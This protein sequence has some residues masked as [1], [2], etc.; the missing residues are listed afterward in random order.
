LASVAKIN[1]IEFEDG[2]LLQGASHKAGGIKGMTNDGLFFEAEGGEFITN[3]RATANNMNALQTINS[4]PNMTFA[5]VPTF[6]FG[7]QIPFET[8][9]MAEMQSPLPNIYLR[10]TDLQKVERSVEVTQKIANF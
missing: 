7:G 4:N 2:G 1:A 10:V 8:K 6:E 3:K 9:V 5:A